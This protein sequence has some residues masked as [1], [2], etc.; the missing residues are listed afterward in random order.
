[1]KPASRLVALELP[2]PA[3]ALEALLQ[4]RDPPPTAAALVCHP[5]PLYG[6]TLHNKVVHRVASTLHELGAVTLRF[7]FRGVGGSAGRHA[8]GVGEL[9]DA[10]AA[11]DW[12]RA[13]A[14]G[15]PLV[16]AGFSFGAAIAGRLAAATPDAHRLVMVAPPVASMDLGALAHAPVPKL[17]IQGTA[18]VTCPPA[19]LERVFPAWAD[20]KRLERVPGATHFF[21]R[22]LPE[23]GRA[24]RDGLAALG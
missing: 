22:M 7:N 16:I 18:D 14:P 23:L 12:L 5:H 8:G 1:M 15:V 9:D 13:R 2:G 19:D 11:L 10:R 21:D 3:G 24:T 6:G 20:P 17:V 4:E